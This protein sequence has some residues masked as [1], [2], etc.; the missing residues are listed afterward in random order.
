MMRLKLRGKNREFDLLGKEETDEGRE[1]GTDRFPGS[2]TSRSKYERKIQKE[3]V[4]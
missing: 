3:A 1:G 2:V 4:L